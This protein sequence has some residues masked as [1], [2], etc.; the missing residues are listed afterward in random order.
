MK[1]QWKVRE[2][3]WGMSP[4]REACALGRPAPAGAG[5]LY[6]DLKRRETKG[7]SKSHEGS[8]STRQRQCLTKKTVETKGKGGNN[9]VLVTKAARTQGNGSALAA[10]AVETR[11][12]PALP[13]AQRQLQHKQRRC[14][15]CSVA[16]VIA[17]PIAIGPAQGKAVSQQGKAVGQQGKAVSQQ[18]FPGRTDDLLAPSLRP[19]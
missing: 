1:S 16:P 11:G 9:S 13:E 10:R 4:Q 7:A 8:A 15:T 19:D 18:P 14:L 3:H 12:K 6:R 17:W 2:R 5:P